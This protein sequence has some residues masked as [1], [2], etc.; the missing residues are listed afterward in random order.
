MKFIFILLVFSFLH[1]FSESTK[2][3][4][5]YHSLTS[6]DL[7]EKNKKLTGLKEVIDYHI[8]DAKNG[9]IRYS[10][11]G[12][13]GFSEYTIWK[14]KDTRIIAAEINYSCGPACVISGIHFYE[15]QKEKF[16]DITE[17]TYPKSK[18]E[19]LYK[20]KLDQI[21]A[22]GASGNETLWISLPRKGLDIQVGINQD[23]TNPDEKLIPV[24]ILK[25]NEN[26]FILKAN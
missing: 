17:K 6:K 9:F 23:P 2:D 13:E 3:V 10:I 11:K 14:K 7:I 12:V 18:I 24:A 1:L 20:K 4:L 25:W 5:F 8:K 21:Q 22:R 15:I 26:D 19:I 16:S